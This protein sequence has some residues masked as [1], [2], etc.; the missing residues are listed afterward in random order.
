MPKPW[1][2]VTCFL[3]IS[4]GVKTHFRHWGILRFLHFFPLPLPS[5]LPLPPLIQLGVLGECCKLPHRVRAEPGHQTLVHLEAKIKRL[6][7]QISYIFNR[8][9][10]KVLL[11]ICS[12]MAPTTIMMTK[13][14]HTRDC[15]GI[16]GGVQHTDR[17]LQVKYWGVRTSAALTPMTIRYNVHDYH[18]YQ[19]FPT[20]SGVAESARRRR[21][22]KRCG[23]LMCD[24]HMR[25]DPQVIR[26]TW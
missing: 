15:V 20:Y 3:T 24:G 25:V 16:I 9:N 4:M 2:F 13:I 1:N 11:E 8:Q 6:R 22:W 21:V 19:Y 12:M 23:F 10:L 14:V 17:S 26:K 18:H 5:L 7:G